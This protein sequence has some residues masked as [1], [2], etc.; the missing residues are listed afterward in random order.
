METLWFCLTAVML[1]AYAILDGFDLG[2]GIVHLAA[3]RS[4]AE[5]RQSLAAIGPV[6]DG[7]E[8]WLIAAGGTLYFAF[9]ALYASAFSGFYL[10]LMV[11]LWL[12]ILRGIS[13][14]FRSHLN[15]P[16]WGSFWDPIF[17]GSSAL[18]AIFFGAALGNVIRGVPLD[19][20]GDFFLPLWTDFRPGP[21]PGILDWYTILCGVAAL[22]VL[23]L[24]GSAWLALKTEGA[25][26]ARAERLI[27]RVWWIVLAATLLLTLASFSVQPRL[28]QSFRERPWLAVFPAAAVASLALIRVLRDELRR[29]LAS[30]AFIAGML[31]S[32]AAGVYPYVLP[33]VSPE[34]PGLTVFNSAPAR[35]GLGIGLAWWI[36]AFLLAA[37]YVAFVYR[38]FAGKVAG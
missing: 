12:L 19:S 28:A 8:V 4:D 38:R 22:A 21:D 18:L 29:F 23:T 10:P 24:H 36:P 5:R 13:V 14:E 17:C 20:A 16:A 33:S 9:P 32:A 26:H 34:H 30:A 1:A 6:W 31:T 7:N 25:V 2:T 37:G 15:H 3:A 11:V 35:Y 27:E